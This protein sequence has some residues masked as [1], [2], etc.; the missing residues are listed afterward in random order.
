M[1]QVLG[2]TGMRQR[3][4][5]KYK[6]ISPQLCI[7]YKGKSSNFTVENPDRHHLNQ[8]INV[9]SPYIQSQQKIR[10]ALPS[11]RTQ[12]NCHHLPARSYSLPPQGCP[13]FPL[14]TYCLLSAQQ[15]EKPATM[16]VRS[17]CFFE[18]NLFMVLSHSELEPTSLQWSQA[19][20][21]W[22]PAPLT[23][24]NCCPCLLYVSLFAVPSVHQPWAYQGLSIAQHFAHPVN[25]ISSLPYFL[26]IC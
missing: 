3:I 12:P 13:C 23:S 16:G 11:E 1:R 4:F 15:P 8:T 5:T 10:Q 22:L 20:G 21:V 19:C 18:Q 14:S 7:N 6:N 25:P 24:P 17:H 9:N 2:K 26:C